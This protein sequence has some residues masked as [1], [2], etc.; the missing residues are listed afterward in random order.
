MQL[1]QLNIHHLFNNVHIKVS[2]V[3][4]Y[5]RLGSVV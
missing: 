1:D 4:T 3:R 5:S 2:V